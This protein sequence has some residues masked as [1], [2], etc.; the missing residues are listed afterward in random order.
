[1]PIFARIYLRIG[2]LRN[3]H[4]GGGRLM[5]MVMRFMVAPPNRGRAVATAEA[6]RRVGD[7]TLG[8]GA[9]RRSGACR[10]RRQPLAGVLQFEDER[11]EGCCSNAPAMN[12]PPFPAPPM[13][14]EIE[15]PRSA[16]AMAT[17]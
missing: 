9:S 10:E 13:I 1:M 15:C 16:R 4:H 6:A 14:V 5:M 8:G 7:R 3:R 17:Y 2:R 11:C 12:L